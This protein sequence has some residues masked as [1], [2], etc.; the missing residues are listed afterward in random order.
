MAYVIGFLAADGCISKNENMISLELKSTDIEVLEKINKVLKNERPIYIS[1]RYDK[2]KPLET[3]KIYFFN[4]KMK[5][6]LAKFNII[7]NKTYDI[8]F[9]YP[10]LLNSQFYSAYIRGYFDGDGSIHYTGPNV[11][12][13]IDTSSEKMAN[14][15]INYFNSLNIFLNHNYNQKTNTILHRCNTARKDYLIQIYNLL[16]KNPKESNPIYLE[17]KYQFFT[18]IINEINSHETIHP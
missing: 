1:T 3:G 12:W 10:N 8:N 6:D 13:Q 18:K 11:T 14:W 9:D 7:P 16:Y 2:I 5:N 4:A 15:F 17:R